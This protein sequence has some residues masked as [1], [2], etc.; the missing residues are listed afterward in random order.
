MMSNCEPHAPIIRTSRAKHLRS[1]RK[2]K[3]KFQILYSRRWSSSPGTGSSRATCRGRPS[4]D[5]EKWSDPGRLGKNVSL[6]IPCVKTATR[7]QDCKLEGS[8]LR[9]RD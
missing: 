1:D 2:A 3:I 4:S 9:Y 8:R 5:K 6:A 7:S